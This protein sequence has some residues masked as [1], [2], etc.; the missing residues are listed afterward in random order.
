MKDNDRIFGWT[1]PLSAVKLHNHQ[2]V[3]A[4]SVLHSKSNKNI[5]WKHNLSRSLII[6]PFSGLLVE[7]RRDRITESLNLTK[8]QL[9]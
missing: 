7:N 2:L 4:T 8:F 3:R 9:H 6:F 1:A 5:V